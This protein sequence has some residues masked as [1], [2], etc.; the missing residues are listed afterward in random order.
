PGN[1]TPGGADI[2]IV[3]NSEDN[4]Q[5]F[6]NDVAFENPSVPVLLQI[7]SGASA[8]QLLPNGS[9]YPLG[10]D[11]SVE[12]LFAHGGGG[13]FTGGP[14]P[15]HLHGH[16]FHVVRSA[17]NSTYNFDNPVMRDVVN[18]GAKADEVT[19]RFVTDNPGPWFLHCHID[20][21]LEQG[22]AVVMAEDVPDVSSSVIPP[23]ESKVFLLKKRHLKVHFSRIMGRTLHE[24]RQFHQRKCG[25]DPSKLH[26]V[27]FITDSLCL[28]SAA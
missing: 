16:A 18:V 4:T 10:R 5:F 15:L 24:L 17:G 1:P 23:S 19:I 9:I 25:I 11:Q 8:S 27:L 7:L 13:V 6:I 12:I 14:H 2:N 22:F 21:H 3:L 26:G 28:G 20:W